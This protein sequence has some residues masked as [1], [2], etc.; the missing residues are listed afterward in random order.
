MVCINN[1]LFIVGI[2]PILNKWLEFISRSD[3]SDCTCVYT[4]VLVLYDNFRYKNVTQSASFFTC[5]KMYK[6]VLAYLRLGEMLTA[7]KVLPYEGK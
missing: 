6:L 7:S 4:S 2:G 5:I 1:H 3:R